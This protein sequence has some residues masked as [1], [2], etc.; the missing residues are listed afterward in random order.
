MAEGTAPKPFVFVLMPFSEEFRDVYEVGIKAACK[1]AGAHCERVDEQIYLETILE[2]VFNQ[3]AK[4]DIVIAEM[5][6]RN[7]NVFYETGYAHALNKQVILLTRDAEDIPFD[8]KQYPHIVYQG[9]I[10]SLKTQVEAKIRWCMDNPQ[11]LLAEVDFN[12]ELFIDGERFTSD[13]EL[14]LPFPHQSAGLDVDIDFH[15]PFNRVNKNDYRVG[16]VTSPI[17]EPRRQ[18]RDVI[19]L[20]DKRHL[21]MIG[22]VFNIYPYGWTCLGCTLRQTE[23]VRKP[24]DLHNSVR[25]FT[26]LGIRNF[27]FAWSLS[28]GQKE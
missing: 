6:G 3:I 22:E 9:S 21:H 19:V 28:G 5:T 23:S 17:F 1:E 18:P 8:L 10:A 16:L 20:P 26:Q 15:N 14:I 7:P 2:R 11:G 13:E 12:L 25:V 27:N 24:E 4:A